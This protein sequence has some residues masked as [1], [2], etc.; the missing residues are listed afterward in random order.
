MQFVKCKGGCQ[1]WWRNV[2]NDT[3]LQT[4]DMRTLSYLDMT[5]ELFYDYIRIRELETLIL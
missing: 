2:G 5:V 1:W 3:N 4:R